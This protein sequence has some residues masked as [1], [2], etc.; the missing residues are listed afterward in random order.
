MDNRWAARGVRVRVVIMGSIIKSIGH[1]LLAAG[2]LILVIY[3]F[4]C[5]LKGLEALRDALNPL[6]P[7]TYLA[8][9]PLTPGSLLLWVGNRLSTRPRD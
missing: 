4:G 3:L 1:G 2:I 8:F 9:L 7:K 5:Y 6:A